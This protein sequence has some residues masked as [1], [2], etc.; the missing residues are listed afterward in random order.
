MVESRGSLTISAGDLL[1]TTSLLMDRFWVVC[2]LWHDSGE[3]IIT[4]TSVLNHAGTFKFKHFHIQYTG[5][6]GTFHKLAGYG[7][8]GEWLPVHT[9][10][11]P[12]FAKFI[13][14]NMY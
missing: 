13:M 4:S 10:L 8:D 1:I 12:D 6:D 3:F 5:M 7:R 2:T 11:Y 9:D 14:G